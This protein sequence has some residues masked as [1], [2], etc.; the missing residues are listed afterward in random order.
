MQFPNYTRYF[1]FFNN[2][3]NAM[4]GY[5]GKDTRNEKWENGVR[6]RQ[7]PFVHPIIFSDF[8][9]LF[10]DPNDPDNYC[11]LELFDNPIE[12]EFT[13]ITNYKPVDDVDR[14]NTQKAFKRKR[15]EIKKRPGFRYL[16]EL[17]YISNYH[18]VYNTHEA[19][20]DENSG[21]WF[22]ECEIHKTQLYKWTVKEAIDTVTHSPR[23]CEQCN[24][25]FNITQNA[26]REEY[27][28]SFEEE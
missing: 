24:S 10:D 4:Y 16:K 17:E 2:E 25:S 9:I 6:L 22:V 27:N 13:E 1:D 23:W 7:K 3:M 15:S 19:S 21:P 18:V 5:D 28:F 8:E 20:G 11:S 26:H 12:N 14:R